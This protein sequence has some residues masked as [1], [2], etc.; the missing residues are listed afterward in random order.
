MSGK[1]KQN[2]RWSVSLSSLANYVGI[3]ICQENLTKQNG[4]QYWGWE[5]KGH[6]N[7]I[8]YHSPVMYNSCVGGSSNS[9]FGFTAGDTINLEYNPMESKL[10]FIKGDEKQ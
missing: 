10:T 8:I 3:G 5:N 9:S 7:Y 4:F 6:G 1:S 2:Y